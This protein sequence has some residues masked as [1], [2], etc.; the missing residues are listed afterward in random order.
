MSDFIT[1]MSDFQTTI[2]DV[3]RPFQKIFVLKPSNQV[4]RRDREAKNSIITTW[5]ISFDYIRE[6]RPSAANL[7]SLMSFFDRQ[8]IPE[9]L[10]RSQ[11]EQRNSQQ[12]Q[13]E[14]NDDNSLKNNP[15]YSD[16][17]DDNTSQSSE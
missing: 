8:A 16:D 17:D 13:K 5:Q 3:F 10:L 1:I 6:I 7:L 14:S 11:D 15:I 2:S 9:A 12:D 4:L